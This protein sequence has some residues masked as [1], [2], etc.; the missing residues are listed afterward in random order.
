MFAEL[1][2]ITLRLFVGFEYE[3]SRGHRF[4]LSSPD[5]VFKVP[6]SGIFKVISQAVLFSGLI[7]Y[8]GRIACHRYNLTWLYFIVNCVSAPN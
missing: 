1:I 8:Y 4:F 3:C 5:R 7:D 6:P 2:D